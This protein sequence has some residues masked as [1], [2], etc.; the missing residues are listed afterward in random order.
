MRYNPFRNL[1]LKLLAGKGGNVC[2]VGD[3]D[4]S[5]YGWRGAEVD[6]ILQGVT[7]TASNDVWAVGTQQPT[8]NT[9]PSV[10]ILH[11]NGSAW[12]TGTQCPTSSRSAKASATVSP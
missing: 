8:S 6:N 11:W 4:Q 12:S 9:D 7:A 1:W 3:D 10:L 5:I 2:V